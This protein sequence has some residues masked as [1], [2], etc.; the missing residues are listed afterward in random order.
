[1]SRGATTVGYPQVG[2]PCGSPLRAMTSGGTTNHDPKLGLDQK[3]VETDMFPAFYSESGDLGD[4][5]GC[6][7]GL[8]GRESSQRFAPWGDASLSDIGGDISG[9]EHYVGGL[10]P[11]AQVTLPSASLPPH[12]LFQQQQQQQQQ[13]QPI[14][15]PNGSHAEMNAMHQQQEKQDG[16]GI[17]QPMGYGDMG[18]N[19][20][21]YNGNGKGTMQQQHAY[22][23]AMPAYPPMQWWNINGAMV[24]Y[25]YY[26]QPIM[27]AANAVA[28]SSDSD[29]GQ[30]TQFYL[31]AASGVAP[32][33]SETRSSVNRR[34]CVERYRKKK[35]KRS[36]QKH[37]RY[38]MRK[39][40]ADK[41]PRIKG[42]FVRVAEEKDS[43]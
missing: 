2:W 11:N 15:V 4:M 24:P 39:D 40:N 6:C 14:M 18:Q 16:A 38:Q 34:A 5:L 33:S 1:M 37:I 17:Q 29:S 30:G 36:F 42:R 35:A 9:F 8:G 25:P 23:A 21:F 12:V 43:D 28:P 13:Q 10:Y 32:A 7:D 41:R 19:Y 27:F 3:D 26:A 20:C 31:G 22:P